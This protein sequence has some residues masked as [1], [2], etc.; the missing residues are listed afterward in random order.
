[1]KSGPT[2]EPRTTPLTRTLIIVAALMLLV[3][4][5]AV[6]IDHLGPAHPHRVP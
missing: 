2:H 3:A 5:G 1:M 4:V 6:I